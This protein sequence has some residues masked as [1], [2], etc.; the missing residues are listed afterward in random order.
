MGKGA[1]LE[2]RFLPCPFTCRSRWLIDQQVVQEPTNP[3]S[4]FA[5]IFRDR[6]Y[7]HRRQRKGNIKQNQE[8]N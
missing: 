2:L 1:G 7:S 4:P 8:F 5:A 6:Q 3:V